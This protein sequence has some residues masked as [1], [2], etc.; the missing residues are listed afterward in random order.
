MPSRPKPDVDPPARQRTLAA[1]AARPALVGPNGAG[2]TTTIK[3]LMNRFCRRDGGVLAPADAA[4]AG[5]TRAHRG[6]SESQ[7]LLTDDGGRCSDVRAFYPTWDVDARPS[8]ARLSDGT[9]WT[10]ARHARKASRA[11]MPVGSSSSTVRRSGPA[12]A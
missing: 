1:D 12:G 3:L 9:V 2:K 5:G 6:M 8:A 7:R 4:R 11:A 10:L